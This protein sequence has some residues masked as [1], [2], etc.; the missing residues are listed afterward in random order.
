MLCII[1]NKGTRTKG[2][3][4]DTADG[5]SIEKIEIIIQSL[6]DETYTPKAVR[7]VYI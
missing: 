7:R 4:N 3:D 5:F 2:I 1:A 6:T